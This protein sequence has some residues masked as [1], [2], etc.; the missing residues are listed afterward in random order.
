MQVT[1]KFDYHLAL[2]DIQ[3]QSPLSISPPL[4]LS[5]SL[6]LSFLKPSLS[7]TGDFIISSY[8][9]GVAHPPGYPLYVTVGHLWMKFLPFG[10]P[11]Y[12]LNLLTAIIGGI[13]AFIV[14]TTTFK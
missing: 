9:F 14:Y 5:L 12:K 2:L 10:N 11:A 13:A 7:S 3:L 1:G 4:S 6:S 8:H